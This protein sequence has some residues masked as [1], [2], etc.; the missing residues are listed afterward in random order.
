MDCYIYISYMSD[1]MS[2]TDLLELLISFQNNNKKYGITGI[3]LYHYGNIIQLFEGP[4][5]KTKQLLENLKND[6]KHNRFK[7]LLHENITT[8]SFPDWNMGFVSNN[9][10]SFNK[11]LFNE[12][13]NK[14]KKFL[15]LFKAYQKVI[16]VY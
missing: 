13:F 15:I 7:I 1:N 6:T 2:E 11:L 16:Q 3:L 14:N 8:R 10:E 4:V 9:T 12:C 5:C